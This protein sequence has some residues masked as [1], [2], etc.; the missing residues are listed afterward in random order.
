MKERL[1]FVTVAFFLL[2][3]CAAVLIAGDGES[4]SSGSS[5]TVYLSIENSRPLELN[6]YSVLLGFFSLWVLLIGLMC[7]SLESIPGIKTAEKKNK[8]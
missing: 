4:I 8:K 5:E 1:K 6:L 2:F 3:M 7:Q